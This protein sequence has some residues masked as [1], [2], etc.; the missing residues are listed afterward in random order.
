MQYAFVYSCCKKDAICILCNIAVVE[1]IMYCSLV[2]EFAFT[3]LGGSSSMPGQITV[4]T[5]DCVKSTAFCSFTFIH[6]RPLIVIVIL[7]SRLKP[8][9]TLVI[10]FDYL[11]VILLKKFK[12]KLSVY[13]YSTSLSHHHHADEKCGASSWCRNAGLLGGHSSELRRLRGRM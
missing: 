7:I 6:L 13:S 3:S 4:C 8:F 9:I 11:D 5:I 10:N 1:T 12:F 2:S